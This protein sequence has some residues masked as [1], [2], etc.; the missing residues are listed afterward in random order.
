MNVGTCNTFS[1]MR[2]QSP[3]MLDPKINIVPKGFGARSCHSV[4]TSYDSRLEKRHCMIKSLQ[5]EPRFGLIVWG[6]T[7]IVVTPSNNESNWKV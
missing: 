5:K 4:P 2:E 3:Q 1:S 7:T 6:S